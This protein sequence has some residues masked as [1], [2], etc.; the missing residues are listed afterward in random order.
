MSW[1]IVPLLPRELFLGIPFPL[2]SYFIAHQVVAISV[3]YG[4]NSHLVKHAVLLAND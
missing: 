4:Y 3:C 2:V 1:R